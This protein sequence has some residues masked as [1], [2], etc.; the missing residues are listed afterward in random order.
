LHFGALHAV[1][2]GLARGGPVDVTRSA[3]VRDDGKIA[4]PLDRTQQALLFPDPRAMY[5]VRAVAECFSVRPLPRE[6]SFPVREAPSPDARRLGTI[7]ARVLPGSGMDLVYRPNDGPDVPFD[8]DWVENDMGYNY[9]RDQ[10]I[11]DRQ[12]DWYLLPPRPFPRAVWI[13]LP[14]RDRERSTVS[15]G[16]VYELSKK[17][18]AR[19]KGTSRTVTLPAGNIVVVAVR[20]RTLEVRK[21][22]AFDSPCADTAERD[23]RRTL[24]TYLVAAEEFY[25]RDLHLQVRPAYTRGC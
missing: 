20:G 3:V 16:D 1:E 24:R 21:E 5:K 6:W 17:I 25:D 18:A 19:V 12:G 14:G 2:I 8:T 7:V 23:K 11:L 9:F 4:V 10:T 13:H 22:E 15:E